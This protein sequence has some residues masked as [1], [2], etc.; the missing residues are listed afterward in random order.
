M[1]WKI[2]LTSTARDMLVSISDRRVRRKIAE[3]IDGLAHEPDKQGK[4]LFGELKGFRSV[5]AVGQRFRIIYAL[6]SRKVLVTVIALG[7]RKQK[8]K[9]D[10]YA[11]TKK[12]IKLGLLEGKE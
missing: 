11:L 3:R 5:R 1:K 6:K 12:M 7:L 8:H 9:S 2:V 10:V 4:V